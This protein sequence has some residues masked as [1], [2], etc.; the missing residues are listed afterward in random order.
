VGSEM[1]IRDRIMG[2][3]TTPASSNVTSS[4]IGLGFIIK[5]LLI[6]ISIIVTKKFFKFKL[7]FAILAKI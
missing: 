3:P 2:L 1:C 6:L 4:S 7:I 5:P